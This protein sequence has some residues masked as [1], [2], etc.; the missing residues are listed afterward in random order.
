MRLER[1]FAVGGGVMIVLAVVLAL[2][3]FLG[4]AGLSFYPA[5]LAAVVSAV[6]GYFFLRVAKEAREYRGEYLR[7]AEEGRPLPPQGPPP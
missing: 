1:G 3:L 5:Y 7:A 4:G 2:G 6:L